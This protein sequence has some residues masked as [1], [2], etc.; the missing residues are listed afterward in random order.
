MKFSEEEM[1]T[2]R[3]QLQKV[4]AFIFRGNLVSQKFLSFFKMIT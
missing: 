3:V 4:G 2:L 1:K